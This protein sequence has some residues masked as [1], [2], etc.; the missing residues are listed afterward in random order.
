MRIGIC[1]TYKNATFATISSDQLHIAQATY[2]SKGF[3]DLALITYIIQH[4]IGL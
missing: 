4:V 3:Y 1:Y 2:R